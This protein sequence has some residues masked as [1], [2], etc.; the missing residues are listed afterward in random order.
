[1]PQILTIDRESDRWTVGDHQLHAGEWFE[2]QLADRSWLLVRFEWQHHGEQPPTGYCVL[3]LAQGQA[4]VLPP[5]GAVARMPA[6]EA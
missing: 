2:L 5:L 4:S 3:K 1:M 6:E